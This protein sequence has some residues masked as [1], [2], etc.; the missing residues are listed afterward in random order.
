[1]L[2]YGQ[3]ESMLPEEPNESKVIT[4]EEC[5]EESLV[6]APEGNPEKGLVTCGKNL[7]EGLARL[8]QA[9][10]LQYIDKHL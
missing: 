5:S 4:D 6:E 3:V 2:T 1:M 9:K 7:E 8:K 10:F